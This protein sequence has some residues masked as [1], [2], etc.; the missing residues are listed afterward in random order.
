MLRHEE[1]AKTNGIRED[2]AMKKKYINAE[3]EVIVF[4]KSS[5]V[6]TTSFGYEETEDYIETEENTY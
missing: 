3:I 5:G 1:K 2:T 4:K 6:I